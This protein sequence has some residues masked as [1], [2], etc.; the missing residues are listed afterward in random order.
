MSL[1][2]GNWA[3]L[4]L[5]RSL[6]GTAELPDWRWDPGSAATD[7]G[8]SGTTNRK[9]SIPTDLIIQAYFYYQEEEGHGGKIPTLLSHIL[10]HRAV[11]FL[12]NEGVT[13]WTNR[14]STLAL[15]TPITTVIVSP[16]KQSEVICVATSP[17]RLVRRLFNEKRRAGDP[18]R[19]RYSDTQFEGE[20]L[21]ASRS[22]Q[23]TGD[24]PWAVLTPCILYQKLS[25]PCWPQMSHCA[26][27]VQPKWETV[28]LILTSE[29]M[30]CL[31]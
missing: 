12:N 6:P 31:C 2:P 10:W 23:G 18:H 20:R 25:S 5:L 1:L 14:S 24:A 13:V 26:P 28:L 17:E 22:L 27:C 3:A 21:V 29:M 15:R 16:D 8:N 4:V 19:C 7:K 11:E 9:F 30:S